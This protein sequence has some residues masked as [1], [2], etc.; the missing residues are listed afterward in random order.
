MTKISVDDEAVKTSPGMGWRLLDIAVLASRH[1]GVNKKCR[2]AYPLVIPSIV[3]IAILAVGLAYLIW[4][5]FQTVDT[6]SNVQ[7]GLSLDQYRNLFTGPSA[8][9]YRDTLLRTSIYAIIVTTTAVCLAIPT[10]YAIVSIK[11]RLWRRIAMLIAICHLAR[12]GSS[13]VP[14][15]NTRHDACD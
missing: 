3:L 1:R 15:C 11:R 2:S 8:S 12:N 4:T 5:S 13:D 7:G 10:A 9:V 14:T 6:N